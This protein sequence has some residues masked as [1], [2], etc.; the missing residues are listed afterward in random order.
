MIA[1]IANPYLGMTFALCTLVSLFAFALLLSRLGRGYRRTLPFWVLFMYVWF[2]YYLKFYWIAVVPEIGLDFLPPDYVFS[3][4][5][6]WEQSYLST[7]VG[8]VAI[9]VT[10]WYC[11]GLRDIQ[12]TRSNAS[13]PRANLAASFQQLGIAAL[14][15]STVL[16]V[17]TTIVTIKTGISVMGM[18]SPELP[19][20]LSG[21]VYLARSVLIPALLLLAFWAAIESNDNRRARV[22]LLVTILFGLAEMLLRSS[23]GALAPMI[24]SVAFLLM[25]KGQ[26]RQYRRSIAT[27]MLLVVALHPVISVYRNL[28]IGSGGAADL[29]RFI[30]NAGALVLKGGEDVPSGGLKLGLLSVLNRLTGSDLMLWFDGGGGHPLGLTAA[31]NVL[32][33]PRGLSGWLTFDA[34]G[35]P[36]LAITAMAPGLFGWFYFVNGNSGVFFGLVAFTFGVYLLWNSLR[37]LRLRTEPVAMALFLTWL[38][39][40]VMDGV[41]DL[42]ADRTTLVWPLSI[43]TCELMARII[44]AT[45]SNGRTTIASAA[46][47]KS[48]LQ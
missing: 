47:A 11:I 12:V 2:A 8:T 24:L 5:S 34:F 3:T 15:T 14:W 35:F 27:V 41:L 46:L 17:L 23:R 30:A 45:R 48:E 36:E 39:I 6:A 20:H 16:A 32:R 21:I 29:G 37:R 33:S 31:L 9:F 44:G 42:L 18:E 25:L 28:R 13:V 43:L 38:T 1:V 22:A 40:V 7:T 10:A 26:L 19:F 4:T